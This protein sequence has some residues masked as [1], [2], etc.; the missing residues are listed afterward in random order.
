[1][2]TEHLRQLAD[3]LGARQRGG[4]DRDLVGAGVEHGLSV[5][6][7][8]DAAADHERDEDVVGGPP[9]QL[10]DRLTTLVRGGDVEEDQLVRPL[11]VVAGRELD[12][13][14]GVAQA[15][16]VGPLDDPARV[17]VEAGD[18]ALQSHVARVALG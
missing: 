2:R 3:Q 4:V 8:T 17:H 16:E 12:R 11:G 1:M 14:A 6:R 10:D 9:R 7:R 18:D 5:V 13:V 15:D